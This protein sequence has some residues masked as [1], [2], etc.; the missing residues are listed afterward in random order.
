MNAARTMTR[1]EAL[2]AHTFYQPVGPGELKIPAIRGVG[3]SLLYFLETA[4]KN[5][6]TDFEA[7]RSDAAIDRLMRSIIS[8]SRCPTTKC[9]RGFVLHRNPGVFSAFRKWKSPIRLGSC[10]PRR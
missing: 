2:K 8:R 10:N 4:G 9:C 7:L 1:A 3:G 6:D 5:W